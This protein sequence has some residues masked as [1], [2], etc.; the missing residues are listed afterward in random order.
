LTKVLFT[1]ESKSAASNWL[2]F[3]EPLAT[4]NLRCKTAF[5]DMQL[6]IFDSTANNIVEI[7][8]FFEKLEEDDGM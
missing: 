1:G 3:P 2:D 7:G 8:S 5:Q 4:R 6:T